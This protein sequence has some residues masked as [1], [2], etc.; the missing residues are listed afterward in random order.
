MP[1][2]TN[3]V[4][5]TLELANGLGLLDETAVDD[6]MSALAPAYPFASAVAV[7][8]SMHVHVK[9]DDFAGLPHGQLREAGGAAENQKD[10]YVKYAFPSGMN[11]IFSS[12]SVSEDDLRET[13]DSRRVRPFLDHYG[14]DIREVSPTTSAIFDA[15]PAVA[16]ELGLPHAAQ[17]G[18]GRSVFC[19]HT[20]VAA[21]HWVFPK[22]KDGRVAPS[23]EI[24]FGPLTVEPGKSGCDLRP[25]DPSSS[26]A[27]A[28]RGVDAPRKCCP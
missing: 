25:A 22:G 23:I 24:A 17:G 15:L 19:C 7:A 9:V 10:G 21:K 2:E 28:S 8:D 11:L 5:K 13:A 20:S 14:I 27:R 26:S 1:L 16:R 12:I 6:V 18:A 3:L 4:K